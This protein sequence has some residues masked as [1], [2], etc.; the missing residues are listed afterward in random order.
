MK[1][2]MSKKHGISVLALRCTL[3]KGS[4]LQ[5]FLLAEVEKYEINL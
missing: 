5:Q 4:K 1:M 2:R 3:L